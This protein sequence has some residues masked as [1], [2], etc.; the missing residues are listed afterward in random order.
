M[1]EIDSTQVDNLFAQL[2][3]EKTAPLIMSA[4]K[5]AG[6]ILVENTKQSLRRSL[7]SGASQR[8]NRWNGKTMEE[9]IRL[10]VDK[11]YNQ[12]IVSILGDFRLWIFENGT[13]LRKTDSGADHGAID[14]RRFFATACSNSE[15]QIENVIFG[16]LNSALNSIK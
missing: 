16:S 8:P 2:A 15:G 6:Q 12:T 5:E 13:G 11:A 1:T 10:T 9:G 7:S 3:P 4:L 14:A